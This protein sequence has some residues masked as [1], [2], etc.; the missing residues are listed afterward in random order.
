MCVYLRRLTDAYRNY[1][2]PE[3]VFEG[4]PFVEPWMR[5]VDGVE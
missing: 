2:Q 3:P 1:M 4:S 5:R